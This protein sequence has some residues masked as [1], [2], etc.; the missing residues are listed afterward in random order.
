MTQTVFI[1]GASRGIGAALAHEFAAR[2][3]QLG[4]LAR[5]QAQLD[6]LAADLR[7]AHGVR[8]ETAS[9][10][11]ADRDAVAP[12]LAALMARFGTVDIVVANAGV[13]GWRKAGDGNVAEDRRIIETNLLGAIAVID[14]AVAQFKRQG[15]GQV[16]GISSISAYRGIPGS[17]AYSASKAALTN[18]LEA[19]RLE[20]AGKGIDVTVVHPGFVKTDIGPNMDKYPFAAEPAK[21]AKEIADGIARRRKNLIVPRFPWSMVLP[22]LKLLPDSVIRKVF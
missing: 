22:A 15:R 17:G 12:V 11:V 21:V 18:Y 14:A 16:V 7:Q 19:L 3:L 6:A 10:D 9:L 5:N 13:L 20:L 8:V 2:G 4:L 1:V